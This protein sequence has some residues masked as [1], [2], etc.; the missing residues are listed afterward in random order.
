MYLSVAGRHVNRKRLPYVE[1]EFKL[2]LVV[3]CR[4]SLN[5]SKLLQ[6]NGA[7]CNTQKNRRSLPAGVQS[8]S[9]SSIQHLYQ[10]NMAPTQQTH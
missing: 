8:Q 1:Q 9:K 2:G 4:L 5:R 7:R 10:R 3:F 6:R